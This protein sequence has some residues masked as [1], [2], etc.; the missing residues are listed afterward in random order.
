M[1][2]EIEYE[3]EIKIGILE[4]VDTKEEVIKVL[5]RTLGIGNYKLISVKAELKQ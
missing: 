3:G 1:K 2:Y 5:N 4:N